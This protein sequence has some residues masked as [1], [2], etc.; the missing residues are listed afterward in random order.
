YRTTDALHKK[1]RHRRAGSLRDPGSPGGQ[2]PYLGAGIWAHRFAEVARE[3]WPDCQSYCGSGPERAGGS[4]LLP[5][6]L[7]VH[8]DE[9]PAGERIRRYDRYPQEHY[10]RNLAP[11]DEQC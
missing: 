10:A 11:P 3:T 1:R 4:A 7:L 2:L 6:D 8:N 9:N 5:R